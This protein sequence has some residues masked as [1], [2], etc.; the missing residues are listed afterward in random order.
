MRRARLIPV[1]VVTLL[2][3]A[4]WPQGDPVGPEFRVNTYTG[5]HQFDPAVGRDPAG[6]FVVVW[7]TSLPGGG[8]THIRGQRYGSSG[9]PLGAEFAVNS[10]AQ[11]SQRYP[12]IAGDAAG[13]FV[14]VW[15][16]TG[17]DDGDGIFAQ[18]YDTAGGAVGIE[19]RV[20]TYTTGFQ[21]APSVAKAASG[22]FVV[23]WQN[24]GQ[25]GV[26]AQRYAAS[27][28]PLG[29]EF[30]V[31]TTMPLAAT[32]SPSVAAG[33]SGNFVV[34]WHVSGDI[35]ARRYDSTGAALGP[36]FRVNTYTT[37]AQLWPAV[38]SDVTD[39]FIV[40]WASAGQ[41]GEPGGGGGGPPFG[42]YARRY[43]SSGVPLGPEFRVNTYTTN[44]QFP[45]AVATDS[46]GNFVI[47]WGSDLQ[48]G[49]VI[50]VFGQRYDNAGV[51]M[52]PEFQINTF[53]TAA[54]A[55]PAVA[56]DS[57]GAFVVIWESDIQDGSGYGIFGQRYAP[58]VP[59]ELMQFRIE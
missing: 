45:P 20:N 4:A 28:T 42:V 43:S 41:E 54:Q 29:P 57:T 46:T 48:D 14:A 6:N 32:G 19:F 10:Y 26:F 53:T 18:R 50:G 44:N 27:G 1:V 35:F 39:N 7:T 17:Q 56:A 5:L 49:S 58:I 25:N 55:L 2:P 36:D 59:V 13:D 37:E 16:G 11:G 15:S 51:P 47:V 21:R 38:A 30:R 34:A 23:A 8:V 3:A 52:G 31:N 33:A 24:D 40:T 9:A 22:D 12:G